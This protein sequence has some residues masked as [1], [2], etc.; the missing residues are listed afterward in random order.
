MSPRVEAFTKL[1]TRISPIET[2]L[3]LYQLFGTHRQSTH[4]YTP[5]E[6]QHSCLP[7]RSVLRP[8]IPELTRYK[9]MEHAADSQT[10]V[11][12][13]KHQPNNHPNAA[14]NELPYSNRTPL[15]L[16][17]KNTAARIITQRQTHT[18]LALARTDSL[19]HST[20]SPSSTRMARLPSRSKADTMASH[21]R[22]SICSAS[23]ALW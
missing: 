23:A 21:S 19:T 13:N 18:P 15:S 10:Q 2:A 9:S 20:T 4:I 17:P 11:N 7:T 14:R 1:C 3:K 12:R 5:P 16:S 22:R 6:K 8:P